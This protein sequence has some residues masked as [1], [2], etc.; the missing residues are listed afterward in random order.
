VAAVN[1]LL[2]ARSLAP[3]TRIEESAWRKKSGK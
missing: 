3:L 1:K 2:S